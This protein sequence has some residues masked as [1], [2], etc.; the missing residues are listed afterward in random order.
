MLLLPP[1]QWID[2]LRELPEWWRDIDAKLFGAP[3]DAVAV[4][5][6]QYQPPNIRRTSIR[7]RCNGSTD[8]GNPL[9]ENS[10]VTDV[11]F[12]QWHMTVCALDANKIFEGYSPPTTTDRVWITGWLTADDAEMVVNL[13]ELDSW[14]ATWVN[15]T[16]W[17]TLDTSSVNAGAAGFI[18]SL[19]N[20][21]W[22]TGNLCIT[23]N[24]GSVDALALSRPCRYNTAFGTQFLAKGDSD[25]LTFV[26]Y[27]NSV[28][29]R[30]QYRGKLKYGSGVV[31]ATSKGVNFGSPNLGLEF[32]PLDMSSVGFPADIAAVA[33]GNVRGGSSGANIGLSE[34]TG[35]RVDAERQGTNYSN[36]MTGLVQLTPSEAAA[37]QI[38]LRGKWGSPTLHT[39]FRAPLAG[40]RAPVSPPTYNPRTNYVGD[41]VSWNAAGGWSNADPTGFTVNQLPAGLSMSN[42]GMVTGSPTTAGSTNVTITN[43][44]IPETGGTTINRPTPNCQFFD[45]CFQYDGD[46]AGLGASGGYDDALAI[47]PAVSPPRYLGYALRCQ[48]GKTLTA[49]LT[50]YNHT[51]GDMCAAF[52]YAAD[53]N[54]AAI[55]GGTFDFHI[56]MGGPGEGSHGYVLQLTYTTNRNYDGFVYRL[57]DGVYTNVRF[58]DKGLLSPHTKDT[59]IRFEAVGQTI[60]IWKKPAGGSESLVANFVDSGGSGT[61]ADGRFRRC[62]MV[63]NIS[64]GDEQ[65]IQIKDFGIWPGGQFEDYA[66]SAFAGT[67]GASAVVVPPPAVQADASFVW[68]VIRKPT[69]PTYSSRLDARNQSVSFNAATGWSNADPTGFS[70]TGLPPGLSCS[71]TGMVTGTPTTNGTT[72]TVIRNTTSINTISATAFSWQIATAATAPTYSPRD[73]YVGSTINL[74]A[75]VG[76]SDANSTGYSATGLPAGTTISSA[77]QITGT[78]NSTGNYNPVISN[79]TALGKT[80]AAPFAWTVW[81]LQVAPTY[82]TRNIFQNDAVSFDAANGWTNANATGF[83]ASGLPAGLSISPAGLITGN[84]NTVASYSITVR[85]VNPAG[86]VYADAVTWNIIQKSVAPTYSARAGYVG[87]SVNFNAASGWTT[88]YPNGFSATNLPPGLS[89]SSAGVITGTPSGT[90]SGTTTVINTTPAGTITAPLAWTVVN[91]P[92]APTYSDRNDIRNQ[93]LNVD[94][95]VGWTNAV[96]TGFSATNLPVG[97]S[98][99]SS[100]VVTGT[101][102]TAHTSRSVTVRN[103]TSV[104]TQ[105]AAPFNWVIRNVP[106][107]PA[108][109][110]VTGYAGDAVLRDLSLGWSNAAAG[111]FSVD[112]L[113]SG[114]S[115]ST[116]GLVTGTPTVAATTAVTVTNTS[117]SDVVSANPF[118]WKIILKPVP[119]GYSPRT[120]R[121]GTAVNFD[122][123]AGWV[124]PVSTGFSATSLP[125]GLSCSS[126]GIITGTPTTDGVFYSVI[127]NTTELGTISATSFAWTIDPP[128]QPAVPP[129]LPDQADYQNSPLTRN[130]AS[131]WSNADPAGFTVDQLPPGLS[132]SSAGLVT[133][134]PT[135]LGATTVTVSNTNEAGTAPAAPFTWT[136]VERPPMESTVVNA[137]RLSISVS[138]SI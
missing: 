14:R 129:V 68:S 105:S 28:N 35:R 71:S 61:T 59:R 74:D 114:L 89:M 58:I 90:F 99:S 64:G 82:S 62:A 121:V 21:H 85:N 6:W 132:M 110:A 24:G 65:Q 136:I 10:Y 17:Q 119:P 18:I 13:V 93:S 118:N 84:P 111:G 12:G 44:G 15:D 16:T 36:C 1:E 76:W 63:W 3:A 73:Q 9:Y 25:T 94:L 72:S 51:S 126:A 66:P 128:P 52:T 32:V 67:I 39:A 135:T 5:L 112:Q 45:N 55:T 103:T 115:M 108:Y 138:I 91:K 102:N 57:V 53:V 83:A 27:A 79:T 120:G 127:R 31:W 77:G 124:N 43:L 37:A 137:N 117:G 88:G 87:D 20:G 92:A 116:A 100:G 130:L 113:P 33:Y 95:S 123:S 40:S 49:A 26:S 4:I 30:I 7:F 19:H 97:L 69:A 80:D 122:A 22:G 41:T 125:P 48:A 86:T 101:P 29:V 50:A 38:A 60:K 11:D 106:S 23:P 75:T 107:A 2:I 81:A 54:N 46:L 98:M 42:A 78:L 96:P 8:D 34:P 131:G 133:G 134:T 109:A 70:A 47:N 56:R 104:D